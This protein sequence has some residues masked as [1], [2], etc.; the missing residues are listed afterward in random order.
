[1]EVRGGF[2]DDSE[3]VE[4]RTSRRRMSGLEKRDDEA[5]WG[6]RQGRGCWPG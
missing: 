3:E 4:E 1:M 6:T 2:G 5:G